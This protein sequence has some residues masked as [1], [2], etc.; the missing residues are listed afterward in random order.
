MRGTPLTGFHPL[1]PLIGFFIVL[2]VLALVLWAVWRL[3]KW[4]VSGR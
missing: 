4:I 1:A 3:I 2:A